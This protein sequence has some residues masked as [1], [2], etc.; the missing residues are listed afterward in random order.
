[1][2]LAGIGVV[3]AL[4][5][6]PGMV[7]TP[8]ANFD[9]FSYLGRF[10]LTGERLPVVP[11]LYALLG[12]DLRLIIVVQCLLAAL[13]WGALA[14]EAL[15][16]FPRP[17]CYVAYGA[18]LLAMASLYVSQWNVAL[19]SDS[20]SLSLLVLLLSLLSRWVRGAGSLASVVIVALLWALTRNTNGYLIVLVGV[21]SLIAA[22][23]WSRRP[24][25]L[26][27]SVL[28]IAAGG[29]AIWSSG[30]GG[31]W[32]QPFDHI[33]AERI[34]T[35]PAKVSWFKAHGMPVTPL[36]LHQA[37]T[38]SFPIDTAL[39]RAPGLASWR[40]W[41]TRAGERTYLLYAVEH[42]LW[43]LQGTFGRHAE[44]ST[45]LAAGSSPS[46]QQWAWRL[47]Y[48]GGPVRSLLPGP[49]HG[50]FLWERQATLLVGTVGT[51]AVLVW[52]RHTLRA[53]GAQL[54]LWLVV[55]ALGWLTL[56]IDWV[57][58]SWELPRHSVGGTVQIWLG[59]AF[60][61]AALGASRT[62]GRPPDDGAGTEALVEAAAHR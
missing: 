61:C 42:P 5:F 29:F 49:L 8:R 28:G 2:E 14:L 6:A 1:V 33:M 17:S 58:D 9:S 10:S 56:V 18:T 30:R 48:Y 15:R 22:L 20:L 31:L 51:G 36:L 4:S 60:A 38:Y 24:S 62:D 25:Y 35:D 11:G 16:A 52:C 40:A 39:R 21:G 19:L 27:A 3:A 13:C 45:T 46:V 34:L 54:M 43:A 57:G 12:R 37:G 53:R 55:I 7:V 26:I 23:I 59:L 50:L 44:F 47:S 41:V 32:L